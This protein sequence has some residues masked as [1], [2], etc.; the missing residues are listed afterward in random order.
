MQQIGYVC[1]YSLADIDRE[2]RRGPDLAGDEPLVFDE[3]ITLAYSCT[4]SAA[5]PSDGFPRETVRVDQLADR[6]FPCD[7]GL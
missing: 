7:R 6:D 5:I 3:S 1:D 2:A 4:H